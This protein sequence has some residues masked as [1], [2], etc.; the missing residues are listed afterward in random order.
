MR[1]G[2]H[3]LGGCC[4]GEVLCHGLSVCLSVC[5]S[6]WVLAVVTLG[7]HE[8]PS[9]GPAHQAARSGELCDVRRKDPGNK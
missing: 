8:E 7:R 4:C 3:S 1:V 5:L 2:S 9:S 6:V